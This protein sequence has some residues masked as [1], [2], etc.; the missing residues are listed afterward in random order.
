M[1]EVNSLIELAAKL[2]MIYLIVKGIG[3]IISTIYIIIFGF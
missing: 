3:I 2:T 1:K